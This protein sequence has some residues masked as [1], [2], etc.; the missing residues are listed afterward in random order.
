MIPNRSIGKK[1]AKVNVTFPIE[2]V[3]NRYPLIIS[4]IVIDEQKIIASICGK[5]GRFCLL[6]VIAR[7]VCCTAE[8]L[9]SIVTT[10]PRTK[11]P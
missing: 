5:I 8:I 7:I 6:H 4:M 11:N 10:L 2:N 3:K 1:C 9:F